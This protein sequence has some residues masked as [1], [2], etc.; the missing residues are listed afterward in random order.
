MLTPCAEISQHKKTTQFSLAVLPFA[1][2]YSCPSLPSDS[3]CYVSRWR[4]GSATPLP[5]VLHACDRRW[6]VHVPAA[7]SALHC[8]CVY[9]GL[10]GPGL[11]HSSLWQLASG[12]PAILASSLGVSRDLLVLAFL[13][14]LVY[15]RSCFSLLSQVSWGCTWEGKSCFLSGVSLAS[16][17]KIGSLELVALPTG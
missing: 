10:D 11:E 3:V 4:C 5:N 1:V 12:L 6:R 16:S 15:L 7:Q 9:M 17:Q 14:F 13:D 2:F 8:P